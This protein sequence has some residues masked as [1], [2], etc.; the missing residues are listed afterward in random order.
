MRRKILFVIG[1]MANIMA[2]AQTYT[3]KVL[4]KEAEPLVGATVVVASHTNA[5]IAY[6]ITNDKGMYKL[7][8]PEGKDAANVSFHFMGYQ[9]KTLPFAELKDGMSVTLSEGG[10]KLREVKVKALRIKSVGDTL[11]YSVAGFRQGQ[12]RSIADVIAKMPGLEVK[13][14]GQILYQGTP[15]NKFYIE[16]LDMMG[17][18]YSMA[19]ENLSAD[20]VQSVQVLE[21]HQPVKS[22]RKVSFSEQA[23]LNIVLKDDAKA[24]W[25]GALDVGA[26]YDDEFLYDCRL[27]GMR[28]DK[29]FQ[30]LMMY[31]NNDTGKELD[32]EVLDLTT[33]MDGSGTEQGILSLMH[34]ASPN[35][36]EDRYTFNH[37]HLVAGNWLFKTGKDSQLR[38]QGDGFIDKTSMHDYYATTYL[39]LAELPVVVEEQEVSNTRSEWQAEA[40]YE[41]NGESTYIK[42]HLKGYMDFNK[43]IGAMLYN[44]ERADM[45]VKPHKRSLSELFELSHTTTKGNV[46]SVD[47]HWAYNYLPGQLLTINGMTERLDLGFFSTQNGFHNKWKIG[48]HYL[49][50]DL[51]IDYDHEDID[52]ALG[53]SQKRSNAYQ[54]LCAYWTP[55]ISFQFG[56]HVLVGSSKFSYAHQSYRES[57]SHHLW[58]DPSVRWNWKA[59]AVSQFSS[60]VDYTNL[61]MMGEAVFDT[62][63]FTGYRTQTINRGK[64]GSTHSLRVTGSY[65]YAN[66]MNGVFFHVSPTYMRSSGNIL[67]ENT[68]IGNVFTMSATDKDHDMQSARLSG[69]I[70]KSFGW[71]KATVKLNASHGITDYSLLVSG[72]V[73][74]A[75]TYSTSTSFSY[76]LQPLRILSAEGKSSVQL[77]RQRNLTHPGLSSGSTTSWEHSLD[78]HI[79][80]SE[81]WMLSV[82]NE[83]FHSSEE[84]V[85][86]SYFLDCS[87]NYM[88]KRWELILT[89]NNIIGTSKFEHRS[90]GNTVMT[91]SVTRLRGRMLMLTF[92]MDL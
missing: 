83:L 13:E 84:S 33:L 87:V 42:N 73:D 39:T 49:N 63:V 11:T 45:M 72:D 28:F 16:G 26:G 52:V 89:A 67:Y 50:N 37:S 22:L 19:S 92:K 41:F 32:N 46:Y 21:N 23:A 60:W 65:H 77:M 15:I 55:S 48:R 2:L 78:L 29:R 47:S 6:G 7:K 62:P 17:S 85:G 80:P 79:F 88:A 4:G 20:K 40:Q 91:Y 61:P 3:G 35:L 90:I 57:K 44:G 38:L 12:D 43:S 24:T 5:T 81:R 14:N 66:P 70:G 27:M 36:A 56:N 71:A 31:K 76:A 75:R 10:T 69:G 74:D 1:I 34:V 53:E 58:I 8:I 9:K 68:L 86:T 30:S 54:L 18:K 25:M 59:T 51:G 64:T 82:D